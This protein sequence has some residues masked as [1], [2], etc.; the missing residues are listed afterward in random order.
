LNDFVFFMGERRLNSNEEEGVGR[1]LCGEIGVGGA[2]MISSEGNEGA[3]EESSLSSVRG[4]E[5]GEE[6]GDLD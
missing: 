2:A 3:G 5:M 1:R 6:T 4:E